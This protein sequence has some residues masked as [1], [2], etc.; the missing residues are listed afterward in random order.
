MKLLLK[1]VR[2][3]VAVLLLAACPRKA[4]ILLQRDVF[5]GI[6]V[7]DVIQGNT[8]SMVRSN[9]ARICS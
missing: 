7:A 1:V 6:R 4:S 9:S 2:K 5:S 3:T 8:V